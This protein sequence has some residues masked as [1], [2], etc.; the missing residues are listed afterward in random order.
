MP[1]AVPIEFHEVLLPDDEAAALQ[2]IQPFA[3][4]F[5][6]HPLT[7][8][9]CTRRN[10]RCKLETFDTYLFL[11]W[12]LYTKY[13]E[14]HLELHVCIWKDSVLVV[15]HKKPPEGASWREYLLRGRSADGNIKQVATAILDRLVDD[16]EEH[17]EVLQEGA[18]ALEKDILD[19]FM[20]PAEVL[21]LKR[22]V[23]QFHR[24]MRSAQPIGGQLMDLS[25]QLPQ[26]GTFAPEEHLRLRNVTDHMTR[27]LEAIQLLESQMSTLMD[28]HWGALGA[29]TNRQMQR[30]TTI[31]TLLLPVSF[32][33]GLFGMNFETMPFKEV[34]FFVA[35][36]V[37][38]GLTWIIVI[39][40]MFRRGVF[41]RE[42]PGQRRPLFPG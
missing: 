1:E 8:E 37:A 42:R 29:R 40:Y 36:M 16:A 3:E 30:L 38:L 17:M 41:L 5:G 33:S 23:R 9:D 34:W 11:V 4:R 15:T 12:H 20:D 22:L 35:G 39:A 31:A 27:L 19:R 10:Q 21:Y 6:L 13:S 14:D 32:W 28:V 25:G 26:V 24:R 7:I 2:A 18:A